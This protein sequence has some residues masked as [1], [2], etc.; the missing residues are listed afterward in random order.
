MEITKR[1]S[2]KEVERF[3]TDLFPL[4]KLTYLTIENNVSLHIFPKTGYY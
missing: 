1:K 3:Y 2:F 4:E